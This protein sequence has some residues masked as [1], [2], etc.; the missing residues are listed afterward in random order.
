[1]QGKDMW[2]SIE[3]KFKEFE[4]KAAHI[5]ENEDKHISAN[6]NAADNSSESSSDSGSVTSASNGR[7]KKRNNDNQKSTTYSLLDTTLQD[8][9]PLVCGPWPALLTT[10]WDAMLEQVRNLAR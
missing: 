2:S 1:M 9:Q 5:A 7:K 8:L 10:N 3:H 4:K 6:P